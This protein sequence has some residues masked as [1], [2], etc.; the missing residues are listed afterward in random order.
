MCEILLSP[1][2]RQSMGVR[3][4]RGTVLESVWGRKHGWGKVCMWVLPPARRRMGGVAA[5][6][7]RGVRG[8]SEQCGTYVGEI[9]TTNVTLVLGSGE[10]AG[11]S[12]HPGSAGR[13]AQG[14]GQV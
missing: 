12:E 11:H 8:D 10:A 13:P 2:W 4:M 3:G 1:L 14:A 7:A 9:W 5:A 6:E